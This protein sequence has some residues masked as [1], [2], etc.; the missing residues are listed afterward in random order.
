MVTR[1]Q[2]AP[3]FSILLDFSS[4]TATDNF[5]NQR[6]LA[7]QALQ[8]AANDINAVLGGSTLSAISSSGTPNATN[9]TGTFGS[10][11]ITSTWQ[12]DYN[13]PSTGVAKS[14][15]APSIAA[16]TMT[17]FVG[18]DKLSSGT[19][20][21]GAASGVT[22]NI[23]GSGFDSQL[24]K[25]T[26]AMETL[27]NSYMTRGGGPIIGH[28]S[29]TISFGGANTASYTLNYGPAVGS[30][31]FDQDTNN[32]GINDSLAQLDAFWHYDYTTPVVAGKADFYSVAL[33]ELLH[34]VGIGDS[35]TWSSKVSG[36]TWLGSNVKALNGGSGAGL[37][38]PDG[39]HFADGLLSTNIYTGAAQE[40]VMDPTLTFGTR[41]QLTQIDVAALKDINWVAVPEPGSLALALCPGLILVIRRRR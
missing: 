16:N 22:I 15:T 29:D 35:D 5:F 8:A 19:L 27:S 6:P 25:A 38:A 18:M 4:D 41:K 21:S 2:A 26:Q 10:T 28:V 39:Q 23:S 17:V 11:S 36:T 1:L 37:I 32:D 20:G 13:D 31:L 30:L 12:Y 24:I 3:G 9:I 7:K 40:T 33:H 34:T 14:I